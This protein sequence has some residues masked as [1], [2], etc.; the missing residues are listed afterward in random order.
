MFVTDTADDFVDLMDRLDDFLTT[1]GSAFGLS[2]S[3]TGNGTFTA[4]RGG[5]SSVAETFTIAATSS[6]NFTVTG[7]VSGSIGPATVGTPFSHAKI[8]FTLTA[9]GTA[10]VSGDT[11]V[12]STAP[13]WTNL[14]RALGC[15]SIVGSSGNT[16]QRGVENLVDGKRVADPAR[17]WN[18]DTVSSSDS[19][20]FQFYESET[21]ASWAVRIGSWSFATTAL[22]LERWTGSAW[23]TLDNR[24]GLTFT[25]GEE[26][27]F[28]ISSPVAASLY[29]VT[30]SAGSPGSRTIDSIEF[31]R[32]VGGWNAAQSQMIWK[33]PGN[34]G[35]QEI[36]V[37]IHAFRRTDVDYHNLELLGFDGFEEAVPL[38]L[39]VGCE[40]GDMLPLWNDE[41]PYWFAANGRSVR[42]LG[43]ISTQY[44]SGY[45]GFVDQYLSP[46]QLEYPLAIGGSLALGTIGVV[47]ASRLWNDSSFR[48]SNSTNAHRAYPMS[49]AGVSGQNDPIAANWH[50]MKMRALDGVYRGFEGA[51]SD[52]TT[53][54]PASNVN[55]VWPYRD[56]FSLMDPCLDG[57][58]PILP[59]ILNLA[60]PDTYGQLDGIGA[61]TGQDITAESLI[62]KGSIDWLVVP[63]VFRSDRNDFFVMAL[64]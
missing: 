62:R 4:Y 27:E 24:T 15:S 20:E 35:D 32:S 2:Y 53:S 13:K 26:K 61:T 52:L 28:I 57:S 59:V 7:S 10:F 3:G 47:G 44:E 1:N 25:N 34:D 42:I 5:A 58:Y 60:A 16:G 6:T 54:A 39:Q 43:K 22:L 37:G 49:D 36:F 18:P 33:G 21:F 38:F 55:I 29:R 64:D 9:G 48:Y 11:F 12:L 63:N 14:R 56:D 23:A 31:R 40:R 45:M 46:V 17:L 50:Q 19:V 30:A 41:I 51:R 8:A